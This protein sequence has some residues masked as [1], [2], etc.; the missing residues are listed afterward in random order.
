MKKFLAIIVLGL[1][2]CNMSFA[3]SLADEITKLEKLYSQGALTKEEY[4]K[5]KEQLLK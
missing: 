4:N 1:L 3:E 2:W 5:A